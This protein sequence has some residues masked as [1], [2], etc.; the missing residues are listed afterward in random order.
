MP[1]ITLSMTWTWTENVSGAACRQPST[2]LS[3]GRIHMGNQFAEAMLML[4]ENTS[5]P[6]CQLS[7]AHS[8]YTS[9]QNMTLLGQPGWE[10]HVKEQDDCD[11]FPSRKLLMEQNTRGYMHHSLG[12]VLH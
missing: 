8:R 5:L 7:T 3:N 4:A 6:Q 9:H 2:A 12:S 10:M 1:V 11:C